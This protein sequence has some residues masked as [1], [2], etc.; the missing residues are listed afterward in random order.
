MPKPATAQEALRAALE[1][2]DDDDDFVEY[3]DG[4]SVDGEEANVLMPDGERIR[5]KL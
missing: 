5:V 3:G 1:G 2:D 4:T